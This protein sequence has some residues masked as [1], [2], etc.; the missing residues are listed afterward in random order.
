MAARQVTR[1]RPAIVC[2][3]ALRDP[4]GGYM[5]RWR[6]W[7][8]VEAP[9]LENCLQSGDR[10]CLGLDRADVIVL[11][12]SLADLGVACAALTAWRFRTAI[13]GR[14]HGE[15]TCVEQTPPASRCFA[16]SL[17]HGFTASLLKGTT[18][19]H[20]GS[21]PWAWVCRLGVHTGLS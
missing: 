2:Q 4:G 18:C 3:D 9:S 5:K 11:A 12:P 8:V 21:E 17:L 20:A 10:C 19:R 7:G 1:G 14:A 16:A 15:I 13:T 6:E